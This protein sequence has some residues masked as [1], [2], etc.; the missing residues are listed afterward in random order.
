MKQPG[1]FDLSERHK[2][3]N[4]KDPLIHLNSLID[5]EDF[6]PLLMK[7]RPQAKKK[8][9]RPAFDVILMY[10]ILI[11]QSQYNV[12]DDEI[13]FQIRDRYSFCRFLGLVAED[14]VPDAKTVWLFRERLNQADL[15]K[16]LFYEFDAQLHIKGFVARKGQIVDASFVEAPRQRNSREENKAVKAGETPESFTNSPN[17]ARQNDTDARWAM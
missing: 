14:R 10:K 9:G 17:K 11:L 15:V 8:M 3:L 13:E 1:L 6:R 2:K 12:S 5:W 16:E 7:S 4:E